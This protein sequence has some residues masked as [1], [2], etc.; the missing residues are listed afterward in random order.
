MPP[1]LQLVRNDARPGRVPVRAQAVLPGGAVPAP[2]AEQSAREEA[3][4]P[5]SSARAFDVRFKLLTYS[6][7]PADCPVETDWSIRICWD[8]SNI[9][10]FVK[11]D[12]LQLHPVSS[13]RE[14]SFFSYDDSFMEPVHPHVSS[15]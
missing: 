13:S 9:D 4:L 3:V 1:V 6:I 2:G 8:L 12:S 11:L 14:L 7:G 10:Q 15:G 5:V